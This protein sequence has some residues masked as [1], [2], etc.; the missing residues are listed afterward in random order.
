LRYWSPERVGRILTRMSVFKRELAR[1]TYYT[2]TEKGLRLLK[3]RYEVNAARFSGSSGSC[4]SSGGIFEN[5]CPSET[6]VSTRPSRGEGETE[7]KSPL[8][9]AENLKEPLKS[10]QKDRV[11]IGENSGETPKIGHNSGTPS[12]KNTATTATTAT[13]PD[14]GFISPSPCEEVTLNMVGLEGL[15]GLKA[16]YEPNTQAS[17]G[18]VCSV[19]IF[20]GVSPSPTPRS[21]APLISDGEGVNESPR[22]EAEIQKD[23]IKMP[24][25]EGAAEAEMEA[26]RTDE[27]DIPDGPLPERSYTTYTTYTKPYMRPLNQNEA[28]EGPLPKKESLKIPLSQVEELILRVVGEEGSI[29]ILLLKQRA[30]ARLGRRLEGEEYQSTLRSLDHK[31]LIRLTGEAVSIRKIQMA[32]QETLAQAL[33][34]L[35]ALPPGAEFSPEEL[36]SRFGWPVDYVE[37]VL[38]VAER[39]GIVFQ[40][41]SGGWRRG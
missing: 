35:G 40:N 11:E 33:E 20:E 3:S 18:S 29:G 16:R 5:T 26:P 8:K 17:V 38:R 14:E 28:L 27:T 2:I 1:G 13:K 12:F 41:P 37:R 15:R 7:I 25:E 22:M 34:R 31:G 10:P 32:P 24:S 30:E 39:E 36:S 19:G 23:S 9:E 6:P 21:T 4:G